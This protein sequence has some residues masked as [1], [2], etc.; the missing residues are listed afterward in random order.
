L[1][2]LAVALLERARAGATPDVTVSVDHLRGHIATRRGPLDEAQRLLVAAAEAAA[3][4]DPDRAVVMLA[5]AVNAAFYAGDVEGMRGAASR[6][7]ALH[8]GDERSAV[9]G[10]IARGMAL[11]FGGGDGHEGAEMLRRA[12][13][14]MERSTSLSDEARL[15]V[16]AAM[17]ALWLRE[18]EAGRSLLDRASDVARSQSA[19]GE[20]PFLLTH[21]GID[22]ASS[23]RWAE[24]IAALHEAIGFARETAQR[25][26][27]A[28]ALARL[29]LIEARQGE[30]EQFDVHVHEA[31]AL[32]RDTGAWLVDI[33][34]LNA[35]GE[36]ELA[37][38]DAEQAA[39]RF[40]EQA[41]AVRARSVGDPDVSPEPELVELALRR[42]RPGDAETRLAAFEALAAAKGQPWS[43][44]RAAR[45]RGLLAP[46]DEIDRH[47]TEALAWHARTPDG[48]EAARTRLAYGG[49]LRRARHRVAARGQLRAAIDLFEHLGARPWSA[50][51]HR[52]LA[53]TGET[54][55]RRDPSTQQ[56]LTPQEL[57]IALVLAEGRT[58]REAAAALFLSPKTIEYHL[59][60]VYRKLGVSSRDELTAAMAAPRPPGS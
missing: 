49:R 51:A 59:R 60:S 2:D 25:T 55:R 57:R 34:C 14:R 7:A 31:R 29:S 33:W 53:A 22:H 13:G 4:A 11:I 24:A 17:A 37:R 44:A 47:F 12:V 26:D 38:G 6:I 23:D 32:A 28:F 42:G 36:H 35:L 48:F 9:F 5:E 45:C 15:A 3:S 52:E 20:L 56:Q 18:A 21:V 50:T 30:A 1:V 40:E 16:W 58:T 41:A 54:A 46:D 43:L 10:E 8:P 39:L 19:I 27:L